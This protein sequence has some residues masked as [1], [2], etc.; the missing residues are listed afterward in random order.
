MNTFWLY[1]LGKHC[2]GSG[3]SAAEL[4]LA[5]YWLANYWAFSF[6]Y[7]SASGLYYQSERCLAISSFS[8]ARPCHWKLGFMPATRTRLPS[9]SAAVLAAV[10][11]PLAANELRMKCSGWASSERPA[12]R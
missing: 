4:V 9:G 12:V 11:T 8:P 10:T 5:G 3:A 6:R 2:E 7:T 1:L